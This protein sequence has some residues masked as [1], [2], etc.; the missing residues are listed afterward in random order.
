MIF[1]SFHGVD[2]RER[3]VAGA[4]IAAIKRSGIDGAR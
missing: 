2:E 4:D 3:R 1:G